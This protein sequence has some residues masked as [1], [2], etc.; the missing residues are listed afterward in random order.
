MENKKIAT[1]DEERN[2]LTKIKKLVEELGEG[3]YI[4]TAFK[5]AFELAEQN[6]EYDFG[7][8]VLDWKDKFEQKSEDCTRLSYQIEEL[9]TN[10]K[11]RDEEIKSLSTKC[12][13]LTA[14]KKKFHEELSE[15]CAALNAA[16]ATAREQTALH[17]NMVQSFFEQ[18]ER[19]IKAEEDLAAKS[20]EVI[21]LKAKLY[22]MMTAKAQPG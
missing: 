3:S 8:S 2:T 11:T 22:D 15:T 5:G 9:Q 6:I 1:K 19:A 13:S 18:Q 20:D 12:D 21:K 17:E 10:L 7:D 16:E 4:G 14:D